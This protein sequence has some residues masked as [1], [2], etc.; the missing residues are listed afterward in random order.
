MCGDDNSEHV[1][2][3]TLFIQLTNQVGLLSPHWCWQD[4]SLL[5]S[6]NTPIIFESQRKTSTL[7][8]SHFRLVPGVWVYFY[9]FEVEYSDANHWGLGVI[10]FGDKTNGNQDSQLRYVH[11]H[12]YCT[13]RLRCCRK[14]FLVPAALLDRENMYICLILLVRSCLLGVT[15]VSS[16]YIRL[17]GGL[18]VSLSIKPEYRR[19]A[20]WL[21]VVDW[22]RKVHNSFVY[23]AWAGKTQ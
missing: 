3:L 14:L 10:L 9:G 5:F 4:N 7:L 21:L 2:T 1:L 18:T 19:L 13:A 17:L 22:N 11:H 23:L 6:Y 8:C 16:S 20:M 15:I 12:T